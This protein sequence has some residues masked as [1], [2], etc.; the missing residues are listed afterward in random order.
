[1]KHKTNAIVTS[2]VCSVVLMGCA[3]KPTLESIQRDQLKA[4]ELRNR[5]DADKAEKRQTQNEALIVNIPQWV[6][7]PPKPDSVGLYAV[8][9][10]E[11]LSLNIAQK[12][13]MLD[14]EF[15][16]AKQYRQEL[17]G[18]ERSF[19]QERNDQSLSSQYTQ[20]I[21]KL[22]SR[23]PIQSVEVVMQEAKSIE[24][25]FHSWVLLKLPFAQFDQIL[26]EQRAQAVDVTVQK[27]FDDLERRLKERAVE[28][29][30]QQRDQ[31]ATRQ[32]EVAS[33]AGMTA[34]LNGKA[35]VSGARL[36]TDETTSARSLVTP[37]EVEPGN[38]R[39]LP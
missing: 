13:A 11:S 26:Q 37:L 36:G 28:R 31:Q 21:D 23:V 24:G 19:T 16:L 14:A 17:S 27:A 38:G 8:G 25:V 39:V 30:Q 5:A 22:V 15:G 12:K 29:A 9:A 6:L 33:Q 2:V 4:E 32:S 3:S 34:Q 10:A 1:M 35:E 7:R 18:S 20:L